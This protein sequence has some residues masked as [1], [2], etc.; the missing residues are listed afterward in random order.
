MIRVIV[1]ILLL[2][3]SLD[4]L[5]AQH[6]LPLNKH[7]SMAAEHQMYKNGEQQFTALKPLVI[8]DTGE[9]FKGV[10]TREGEGKN[11]FWRK[12]RYENLIMV[13]T[14]DFR[15]TADPVLHFEMSKNQDID[16]Y[17]FRNTRGFQVAGRI[18]KKV[19]FHSVLYENQVAFQP[20]VNE[21]ISE[22]KVIPFAANYKPYEAPFSQ[23]YPNGYD[24]AV[25]EGVISWNAFPFLNIQFGQGKNFVG[26]GYRSLLLSDN[27]YSYPYLKAIATFGKIQYSMMYAELMDFDLPNTTESGFRKKRFNMLFLNWQA[28]KWLQVGLFEAT[29][30]NPEDSTGYSNFKPNYINPLILSST[31]EYGLSGKNNVI[32]G[33]NWKLLLPAQIQLY[34]QV[35]LDDL[36]HNAPENAADEASKFGF[37]LGGKWFDALTISDLY[38]QGEI[39]S[40]EPYTYG[41]AKVSQNYGHARQSLAHPMGANFTEMV[42]ILS[43]QYR[44][45]EIEL[46]ANYANYQTDTA[47]NM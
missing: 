33:L 4:A 20:F 9:L 29:I 13:E 8:S 22:K 14:E 43:Y 26:D 36:A 18:G 41:H 16:E 12:L 21:F 44:D 39:N 45:F 6:L 10:Y 46:Q 34:G 15:F 5:M 35:V 31:A 1:I 7:R 19:A 17:L 28:T 38:L 40:V 2:V 24:F 23:L 27:S 32:L 3:S 30:Y 47:L 25:A 11:W 42:G 37:Q